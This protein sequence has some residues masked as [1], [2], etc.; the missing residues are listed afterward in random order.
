MCP[1]WTPNWAIVF[2]Q[3]NQSNQSNTSASPYSFAVFFLMGSH[4]HSFKKLCDRYRD[5]GQT[6]IVFQLRVG[7]G[8]GIEKIFRVAWSNALGGAGNLS[9]GGD[10]REWSPHSC[11]SFPLCL[12]RYMLCN[13]SEG[14]HRHSM[15]PHLLIYSPKSDWM[16][17]PVFW[18]W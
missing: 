3:F 15:V 18:C 11:R 14:L 12:G 9:W 5:Q 7:S 13:K 8:S 4:Y 6:G 1:Y 17:R 2:N 10:P 16:P